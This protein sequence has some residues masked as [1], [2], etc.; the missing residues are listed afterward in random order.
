M[1][2]KSFI[3]LANDTLF[4]VEASS[5]SKAASEVLGVEKAVP[6]R[7]WCRSFSNLK[8]CKGQNLQYTYC[9]VW[10]SFEELLETGLTHLNY[11]Y[12]KA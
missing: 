3:I 2:N 8:S 10:I 1:K 9:S 11:D 7:S 5:I 12:C 4:A 6:V